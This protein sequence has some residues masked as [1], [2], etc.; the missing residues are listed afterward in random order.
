MK[1]LP[2]YESILR[3]TGHSVSAEG[4]VSREL[5]G[6][7]VMTLVD[8]AALVLPTQANMV[9]KD[10]AKIVMFHPLYEDLMR[11][12]SK[13]LDYFR[14]A[15]RVELESRFMI[16]ILDVLSL[17]QRTDLH[18]YV[19]PDEADILNAAKKVDESAVKTFMKISENL[20]EDT[21]DR[22][23][24]HVYLRRGGKINGKGYRQM[25]TVTF[26]FYEYLNTELQ[27]R[28]DG[29]RFADVKLRNT[30]VAT[31]KGVMEYIIP[32]INT[33]GGYSFGSNEPV[34]PKLHALL[35][36]MRYL[37]QSFNQV[38]SLLMRVQAESQSTEELFITNS[39]IPDEW[40]GDLEHFDRLWQEARGI[41][42]QPGNEGDVDLHNRGFADTS[43]ITPV[44]T[45]LPDLGKDVQIR[46][47]QPQGAQAPQPAPNAPAAKAPADAPNAATHNVSVKE[48]MR[49]AFGRGVGGGQ[50]KPQP[51]PVQPKVVH[52][53]PVRATYE[54]REPQP[55]TIPQQPMYPGY[56][57]YPVAQPGMVPG[58]VYPGQP[59]QPGMIYPGQPGYPGQP[60]MPYGAPAQPTQQPAQA[61]PQQPKAGSISGMGRN[62]VQPPVMGGMTPAGLLANPGMPGMPYGMA[63]GMAPGMVPPGMAPGMGYPGQ[64]GMTPAGMLGMG[65]PGQPGMVPPG[66]VPPG[67]VPAGMVPVH[68]PNQPFGAPGMP[69]MY[70]GSP[71]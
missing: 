41:P 16:L 33:E 18:Q 17:I 32:A 58:M 36:A 52:N 3:A 59:V 25:A 10:R 40:A 4:H 28:K 42:M 30:D 1:L 61:Q 53:P 67:M 44:A 45:N 70:Y 21:R 15:I 63:P 51:A 19:S 62:L 20:D 14:R 69:F 8:S 12:P 71:R 64:P 9:N 27:D 66:M 55:I 11:G 65:Y 31:Y 56:P 34:A 23:L 48:L 50:A 6:T 60:P 49:G 13:V 43:N 7:P 24:L 22:M 26:P 68:T 38:A 29:Y 47:V 57:G 54:D 5:Y 35:G 46:A 39:L 37:V 2:F